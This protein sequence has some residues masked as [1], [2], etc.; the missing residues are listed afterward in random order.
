MESISNQELED[1]TLVWNSYPHTDAGKRFMQFLGI[2]KWYYS[3]VTNSVRMEPD[4]ARK[5]RLLLGPHYMTIIKAWY[6]QQ[7]AS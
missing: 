5:L 3:Y 2:T 6:A 4:A 1:A 7:D